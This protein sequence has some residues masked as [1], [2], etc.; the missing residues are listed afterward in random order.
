MKQAG[1]TFG[2]A[3]RVQVLDRAL[4]LLDVLAAEGNLAPGEISS[5]LALHK[6]TVHRLLA[7]LERNEYV[8]RHQGN[9]RYSLGFKLIELGTSA[10][11]RLDLCEVARPILDDLMEQTGET[12]HIGILSQGAVVSIADSESYKTLRT[13]STVGRRTPAHCSSQ[14]KVLLAEMELPQVQA[15]VRANGLKPYTRLTIRTMRRLQQELEDVR[16]NGYAIDDQEFEE[17]LKCIGAPI[18]DRSGAVIAGI[19]VAGPAIRL[20]VERMPALIN[21]VVK[22]ADRISAALG[23]R[24]AAAI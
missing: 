1:G 20:R 4:R 21:T 13:P 24:N 12:A 15:F 16:R 19:S 7:V 23:Y 17:G 18:R 22:A 10:S 3:Y 8:E 14:G 11:S 5:R 9:G 2:A 6:S